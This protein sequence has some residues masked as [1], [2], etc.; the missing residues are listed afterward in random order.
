MLSINRLGVWIETGFK[1]IYWCVNSWDSNR[2]PSYEFS[3]TEKY[4][5]KRNNTLAVYKATDSDS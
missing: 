3:C 2:C 1:L 5:D 4:G